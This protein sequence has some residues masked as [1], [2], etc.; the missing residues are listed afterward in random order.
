MLKSVL[1]FLGVDVFLVAFFN[2]GMR[3]ACSNDMTNNTWSTKDHD[4]MKYE[5]DRHKA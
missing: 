5:D 1:Q 2:I 4:P 3:P